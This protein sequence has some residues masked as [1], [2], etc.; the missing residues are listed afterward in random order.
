ML[1]RV[2]KDNFYVKNIFGLVQSGFRFIT[3]LKYL[4]LYVSPISILSFI[5]QYLRI[6]FL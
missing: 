6:T 4:F 5:M 1:F 2:F 3:F